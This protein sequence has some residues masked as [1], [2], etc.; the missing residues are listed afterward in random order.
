MPDPNTFGYAKLSSDTQLRT[1]TIDMSENGRIVA[2]HGP[3]ASSV[4]ESDRNVAVF[5]PDP[6]DGWVQVGNTITPPANGTGKFDSFGHAVRISADGSHLMVYSVGGGGNM[7]GSGEGAVMVYELIGDEWIAR[8]DLDPHGFSSGVKN[9][10]NPLHPTGE[11]D[12]S[13]DGSRVVIATEFGRSLFYDRQSNGSYV[14]S[15]VNLGNGSTAV[16]DLDGNL[17]AFYSS[18]DASMSDDGERAILRQ[19][20]SFG[21]NGFVV[22]NSA[23]DRWDMMPVNSNLSSV[24]GSGEISGDGNTAVFGHDGQLHFARWDASAGEWTFMNSVTINPAEGGE[25]STHWNSKAN[26]MQ[27]NKDGTVAIV[28]NPHTENTGIV[29]VL[30]RD[31][32]AFSVDHTR[33]GFQHSATDILDDPEEPFSRNF[34]YGIGINGAGTMMA[35]A[36]PEYTYLDDTTTWPQMF[37]AQ[38]QLFD[39]KDGESTVMTSFAAA[40]P[41]AGGDP[42]I[43]PLFGSRY[44]I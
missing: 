25:P 40:A 10:L 11:M 42:H 44:T 9:E 3:L 8:A 6:D 18:V 30:K 7:F 38:A 43:A 15:G 1:G 23:E 19:P 34:G 39:I 5:D 26:M 12:I 29:A 16:H 33:L 21:D 22:F 13:K 14:R 27:I 4:D 28:S 20:T 37:H 24:Q 31:G 32:N 17:D 36:D 35:V 41:G 2:G